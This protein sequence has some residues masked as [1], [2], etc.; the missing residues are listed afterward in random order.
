MD[1][2]AFLELTGDGNPIHIDAASAIAAG[3]GGRHTQCSLPRQLMMLVF[4][5]QKG[6]VLACVQDSRHPLSLACCLHH[7]SLLWWGHG[8]LEQSM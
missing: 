5:Q 3:G 6:T 1:V 4:L 7:F 8:S 2:Q